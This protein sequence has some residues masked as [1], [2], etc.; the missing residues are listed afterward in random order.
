M[1][2]VVV[3]GGPG[4]GKTTLLA[5]LARRGFTVVPES[6]RAVI[7]ERL[8]QGLPPRPAALEFAQEILRRDALKYAEHAG[9]GGWVFFDRCALEA[10]GML[11]EVSS[12]APERL[13]E[14]L[15]SYRFCATVFVLPPWP[16]IYT[17]D[18]ERDHDFEHAEAVHGRIVAWYGACG[19]TVHEVPQLPVGQRAEHV[20]NAL[21]PAPPSPA[22]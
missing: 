19:H 2:C 14:A 11:H 4:A 7:A 15:R 17:R 3:T 1:P 21:G 20:L 22:A 6:A 18:A 16:A 8:A 13:A 5:E 12:M 9:K 10:I